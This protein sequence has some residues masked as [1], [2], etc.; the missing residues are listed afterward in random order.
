[1]MRNVFK[2]PWSGRPGL[3]RP[4]IFA[5]AISGCATAPQ[6]SPYRVEMPLLTMAPTDYQIE[7][8]TWLRCYDRN[9]ALAII[10][11]LK[12]ACLALGGTPEACQA[13]PLTPLRPTPGSS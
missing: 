2:Q 12:A 10:R 6:P 9:D 1:M 8:G 5:V 7:E 3:L 13:A 11:E 4:L